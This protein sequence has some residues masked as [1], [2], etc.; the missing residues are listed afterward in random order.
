MRRKYEEA[1]QIIDALETNIQ[2][3]EANAQEK[4]AATQQTDNLV[5]IIDSLQKENE[6]LKEL[7]K[8]Q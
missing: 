5:L 6:K 1:N 4:K 3:Y 8:I 2:K 7:L